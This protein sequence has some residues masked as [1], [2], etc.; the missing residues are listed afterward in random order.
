MYSDRVGG[1]VIPF[2]H[3]VRAPVVRRRSLAAR[4]GLA[5]VKPVEAR[6]VLRR[7]ADAGVQA[8]FLALILACV[9][10]NGAMLAVAFGVT[11]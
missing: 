11:F 4:G 2:P 10:A 5:G 1:V 8:V 9:A 7:V 3:A 6:R